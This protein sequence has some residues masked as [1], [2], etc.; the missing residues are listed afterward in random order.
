MIF[1]IGYLIL[2]TAL[3]ISIFGIVTGFLGGR[4]RNPRL[5]QSSFNSVLAV[6]SNYLGGSDPLVWSIHR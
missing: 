6:A 1:N 4:Q 3:L 2:I 5:I